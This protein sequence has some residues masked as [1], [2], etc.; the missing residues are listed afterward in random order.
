MRTSFRKSFVRDLNKIKDRSLLQS[1][2]EVIQEAEDAG[3]LQEIRRL[4]KMSGP[5]NFYRIRL[6]DYRIGIAVDGEEGIDNR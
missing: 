1:V 4:K 5:G 3:S 2:K 6:G